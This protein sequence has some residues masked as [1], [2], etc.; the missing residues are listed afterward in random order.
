VPSFTRRRHHD[1]KAIAAPRFDAKGTTGMAKD[2]P[3][4]LLRRRDVELTS[5][6]LD[7][8]RPLPHMLDF[9]GL[10]FEVGTR[11]LDP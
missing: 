5:P 4:T 2:V 10:R 8:E 6:S 3:A 1:L 11:W 9:F 7:S